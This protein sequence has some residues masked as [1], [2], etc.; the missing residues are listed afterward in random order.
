MPTTLTDSKPFVDYF[1]GLKLKH[2][3]PAELLIGTSRAENCIPPR[4]LWDNMV[5]TIVVLDELRSHFNAPLILTSVYRCED[6]NRK[7][8]S[9]SKLS[10][11]QAFTA[12]DFHVRGVSAKKAA[13]VLNDWA[14]TGKEFRLPVKVN[15]TGISCSHGVI[16]FHDVRTNSKPEG[17]YFQLAGGISNYVNFTHLDTRGEYVTW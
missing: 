17:E 16:P 6:Y 14:D 1:N 4:E 11:H 3:Q 9:A 10:Q 15:R 12:A 5:M 2:F 13:D 8:N 7:I